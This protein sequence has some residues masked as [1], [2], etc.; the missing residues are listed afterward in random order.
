MNEVP[1]PELCQGAL[2]D[3]LLESLEC[4]LT[5][6]TTIVAVTVKG[7]AQSRAT[8]SAF[9]LAEALAELRR[10][11]LRGVQVHYLWNEQAWLD[12]LLSDG[13]GVRLIRR[14]VEP[15]TGVVESDS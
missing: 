8:Q 7:E 6:L 10:G 5:N 11:A 14:A 3:E 1:L 15:S 2:D 4:D 13:R 9:S 12:T